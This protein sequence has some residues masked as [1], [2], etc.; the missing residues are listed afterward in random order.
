MFPLAQVLRGDGDLGVCVLFD[1]FQVASLLPDQATNKVVVSQDLQRNLIGSV[2][3]NHWLFRIILYLP[4]FSKLYV[5]LQ[6]PLRRAW[7]CTIS[8]Q[9][10]GFSF[11]T[12]VLVSLA[13]CCMISRIMRQAAEQP[14]G[15]EWML[16]GFSAAPA[17]SLRCT[18]ILQQQKKVLNQSLWGRWFILCWFLLYW[19]YWL[20]L[21]LL[22]LSQ[23]CVLNQ[24]NSSNVE[25]KEG[26]YLLPV[27]LVMLRMVAPSLPM[28]APTYC[29]GTSSLRGMSACGGL[30]GI[31]ELG[32]PPRG[33][34]R[35]P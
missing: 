29:V 17:F 16:I 18:S 6:L 15:L 4:A 30:L 9:C 2:N 11:E 33:P 32:E 13:S 19:L 35:G 12:Y 5:W 14:S 24:I 10:V 22:R 26:A 31:P 21:G 23:E 1:F 27:C 3:Q 20:L 28:I 7:W 25:A 8:T 34:P